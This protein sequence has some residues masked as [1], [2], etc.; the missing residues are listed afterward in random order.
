MELK[1]VLCH[2][3]PERSLLIKGYPILCYRCIGLVIG[4]ILAF[5]LNQFELNLI[6]LSLLTLPFIVDG[7]TQFF[8]LRESNNALRLIT[9]TLFGFSIPLIIWSVI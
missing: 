1:L 9:G 3:M 4:F 5:I 6:F 2:R 8:R 7:G